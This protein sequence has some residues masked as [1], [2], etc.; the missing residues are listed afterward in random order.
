MI[1]FWFRLIMNANLS[2]N[3]TDQLIIDTLKSLQ[4]QLTYAVLIPLFI[5]G[6]IGCIFNAIIFL[7]PY[8]I[9]SSCTRY[10]LASSFANAFQL[11]IGLTG[12]IL[13]FGFSIHPYH[14]SSILCKFRNYLINIGGFLSQTYL[15]FACIDRYLLTINKS[16]YRKLNTIPMANRIICFTACLW[17]INLSHMLIYSNITSHNQFCFY[18]SSSYILFISLHNLI[19]SGFI[20]PILMIIFGFLTLKNMRQ[21]RRRA[22]SRQRRKHYLSLMLISNVFVNVLF[23]LIYTSGLIYLS[24]FMR[25]KI[26]QKIQRRF[27]SFIAIIFYYVP[28]AISFYVNILT[29]QRFRSELRKVIYVK[30][31][32]MFFFSK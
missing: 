2:M 9:S 28:Y 8:L 15:L 17:F 12:N 1:L 5:I 20:L 31:R 7:R 23:T 4:K 26:Q 21:I 24:F 18:S 27:I 14:N 3:F 32:K 19:L 16:R 13:D 22:R 10:F 29:S 6:N 11:N 30:K 25:N